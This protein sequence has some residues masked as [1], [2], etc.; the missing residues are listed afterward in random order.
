MSD[1]V[2]RLR[3]H[4]ARRAQGVLTRTQ[5]PRVDILRVLEPTSLF[6]EVYQPM[7]SL[8]LQGE[9]RLFIGE[10]VVRYAEAEAFVSSVALPA[11]GEVVRATAERPYLALRLI[12]DPVLVADLVR[13]AGGAAPGP[14]RRGFD[15]A[16]A[17]DRLADA[18]LRMLSL[19]DHPDE[20]PVMAPLL[21][22]EILFRLL[23]GP[24]GGLLRQ[25]AGL[26]R[27]FARI[28]A[29]VDWMR[30]HAAERFRVDDLADRAG[31]SVSV[32]HRRFKASTGLSPLR[33]QK[34]LRLY[35]ARRMLLAERSEVA[36]VAFAVGYES[37]SQFTREYT[38]LFG[39]PP[40]RDSRSLRTAA[41]AA[42]A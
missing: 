19:E 41:T 17:T 9:K 35:E 26:D 36:P 2:Q 15:V 13:Q 11:T 10:Q 4:V 29:T 31:M 28:R 21:E 23:R 16:A 7:V 30:S 18:W 14:D 33:Y 12:L 6:P 32:F 27:D 25:V 22:R 3:D 8:I 40:A 37:V 20:I 5:L 42:L 39:A 1:A 38:R 34:H 24:Q